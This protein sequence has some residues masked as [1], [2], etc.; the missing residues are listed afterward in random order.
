MK[1]HVAPVDAPLSP[2]LVSA[3]SSQDSRKAAIAWYVLLCSGDATPADRAHWQAWMDRHPDHPVA[4]AR[5]ESMRTALQRV[6]GAI[7]APVLRRAGPRRRGVLRAVV[8][9]LAGA[10]ALGLSWRL[11][12]Q[13]AAENTGVGERRVL[14]LADGSR[15]V[16][17]TAT[18]LDLRF[19]AVQRLV[20][21][22]AGEV[23]IETARPLPG[24][25]PDG[26]PFRVVTPQGSV[27]ALGTRFTVRCENGRSAVTVLRDAVEVQVGR[28]AHSGSAAPRRLAAGSQVG[29][30]ATH[31]EPTTAADQ[32]AGAWEQGS[33]VVVD[34]RLGDL[35]AELARY[36][37]GH[38]AC[39]PA[40]A[41][42]RVS[43]AF[44]V[45]DTDKALAVLV[46]SLPVRVDRLS[47]YWVTVVPAAPMPRA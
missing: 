3:V 18:S 30:D 46:R 8:G 38:L 15:L 26:R 39:D 10:S 45:G 19:D 22:R 20:V 32:H 37:R 24:R 14:P 27:R 9:G 2:S 35:V 5:I 21:L 13:R 17:N 31:V 40:V 6:P 34:A 1:N 25:A 4:W 33:L 47:A 7:A 16:M 41:G 11:V 29:F 44:P 23:W 12:D 43:G 42:L 36:R 28:S